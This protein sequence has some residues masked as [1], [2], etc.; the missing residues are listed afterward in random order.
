MISLAAFSSNTNTKSLTSNCSVFNFLWHNMVGKHLMHFHFETSVFE[1]LWDS[2][3]W[4]LKSTQVIWHLINAF[5]QQKC[6]DG[7]YSPGGASACHVCPAGRS[8][9]N[10][11]IPIPPTDCSPGTYSPAGVGICHACPLGTHSG[12]AASF[13]S[14][15]PAGHSCDDPSQSPQA[16]SSSE[17]WNNGGEVGLLSKLLYKDI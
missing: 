14:P 2:V 16:C 13:C 6:P 11:S 8:C 12:A 5:F 17:Y 1:F 4:A 7:R 3:D 10:G 9:I 15:C